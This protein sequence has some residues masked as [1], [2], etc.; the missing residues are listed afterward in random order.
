[1][2][3]IKCVVKEYIPTV[4]D[5]YSE[6]VMADDQPLNFT[7]HDAGQEEYDN[8]RPLSYPQTNCFLLCFSLENPE[9]SVKSGTKLDLRE[10][11]IPADTFGATI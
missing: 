2:Q 6:N 7:L 4:F 8:I 3:S 1:M 11:Q 10:N 5:D 9:S